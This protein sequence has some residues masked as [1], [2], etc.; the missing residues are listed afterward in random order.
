M[1][2]YAS[3]MVKLAQSWIG[4]KESDKSHKK[5]IDIYNKHKP[6]PRGYK[7][8][9][10]D[11]WCATTMSALAINLGYTDIIPIECSC[12]EMIELAKKMKIWVEDDA[13]TPKIGDFIL[14]DWDDNGKGDNKGWPD[15]IGIIEKCG[16]KQMTIIEGNYSNAVKRRNMAVNAKGI[17]GFIVPKYDAE[18][19]KVTTTTTTTKVSD[20]KMPTIKKGSK[21]KAVKIWQVIIGAEPDG[22]FGTDTEK[23]TIAFQKKHGLEQDGIAGPKSWKAGLES[24]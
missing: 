19:K 9:L 8:K 15:H 17:R 11:N 2:M 5:I 23:K 18:P 13:Y 3:E 16:N 21:G 6:L 1:A 12:G 4:L 7:V 14:Y 22:E 24:V 10:T 20:T